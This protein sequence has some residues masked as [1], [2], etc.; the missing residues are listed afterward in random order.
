MVVFVAVEVYKRGGTYRIEAE[1]WGGG[2]HLYIEFEPAPKVGEFKVSVRLYKDCG[3]PFYI[4]NA[5][6]TRCGLSMKLYAVDLFSKFGLNVFGRYSPVDTE[7]DYL[8]REF[9]VSYPEY[10]VVKTSEIQKLKKVAGL[11]KIDILAKKGVYRLVRFMTSDVI[12]GYPPK[13][14]DYLIGANGRLKKN[15]L[16][17]LIQYFGIKSDQIENIFKKGRNL[18]YKLDQYENALKFMGEY[19]SIAERVTIL[20]TIKP[21][22]SLCIVPMKKPG[23]LLSSIYITTVKKSQ[24][25]RD[26]IKR[27]KAVLKEFGVPIARG[28]QSK[29]MKNVLLTSNIVLDLTT[30]VKVIAG[31]LGVRQ[32]GVREVLE[33]VLSKK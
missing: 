31:V 15:E 10:R 4:E 17:K 29:D 3:R 11:S 12:E 21:A 7:T 28:K 19:G 2:G 13:S 22:R 23:I 18:S 32:K 9:H 1:L 24:T 30:A 33:K 16:L 25:Y 8:P 20:V 6:I 26:E 27:V 14:Y 5:D